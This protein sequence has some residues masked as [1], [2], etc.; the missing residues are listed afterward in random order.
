MKRCVRVTGND[1]LFVDRRSRNSFIKAVPGDIIDI[2]Y[3]DDSVT[4]IV[5]ERGR[6]CIQCPCVLHQYTALCANSLC[7]QLT[8]TELGDILEEL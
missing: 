1:C 4:V 6:S 5:G 3:S 2:K 8:Y 7:E